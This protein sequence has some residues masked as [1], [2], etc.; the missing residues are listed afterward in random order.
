M[1][2]VKILNSSVILAKN[3]KNSEVVLMGKGI[4]YKHKVGDIIPSQEIEKVYMLDSKRSNIEAIE[5]TTS[6]YLE[7]ASEIYQI[8]ES[9][10]SMKLDKNL[11]IILADHLTFAIYRFNN[12]LIFENKLLWEIQK[13]YHKEYEIGIEAVKLLDKELGI[14][15]DK[16][17][18][19]NIAFHIVNAENEV[20][21]NEYAYKTTK[22]VNDILTII[23]YHY[24]LNF[25]ES[26]LD[27]IRFITHLKFFMQRV[28]DNTLNDSCDLFI[29][30]QIVEKYADDFICVEKIANYIEE[31]LKIVINEDEKV[32]LLIHINRVKGE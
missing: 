10:L 27:Y 28:I 2:V 3:K 18:A 12:N 4:G 24:K 15:I 6:Q 26:S 29:Y 20:Y 16:A 11:I 7:I 30:N 25:D 31:T 17:E 9:K 32:Y 22:F 14:H 1:R 8:A 5:R 23:K 19:A 13:Y 21:N